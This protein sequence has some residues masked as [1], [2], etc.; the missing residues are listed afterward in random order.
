MNI[1]INNIKIGLAL[2]LLSLAFGIA[3]GV[4]FGANEE[5]YKTSIAAGIAANPTMHDEKSAGKIWRFA[6][7]AHFHAT[8]ISSFALGLVILTMFTSMRASMQQLTSVLIGLSGAYPLAWYSIYLLAPS[9]GRE[10]AHEHLIAKLLTLLGVGGLV[11][12][13]ALL[14]GNI[15]LGM[16]RKR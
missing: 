15:F 2:V 5:G 10:A 7:R 6:Q 13:I 1:E 12:G 9:I 16:F 3:M 14:V 8:G 4:S 11:L